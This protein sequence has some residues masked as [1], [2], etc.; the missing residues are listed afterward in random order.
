M[1]L[2]APLFGGAA[3]ADI[4]PIGHRGV[5]HEL[6]LDA[7]PAVVEGWQL[8]A[9]PWPGLSGV[10]PVELGVPF[11]FSSKYGTRLYAVARD[12]ALPQHFEA[13][14]AEGRP[15]ADF[16]VREV[17]SVSF[18]SLLGGVT[19]T[20]RVLDVS[21]SGIRLELIGEE[22]RDF[23]G[24]PLHVTRWLWWLAPVAVG[25]AG[26]ALHRRRRAQDA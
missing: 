21:A 19:T 22:R 12:E 24:A 23:T 26:I 17:G 6:V 9:A 13:A 11:R 15:S 16:G 14:W 7:P 3:G 10:T 1:L 5:A 8:V 18:A 2:A 20:L 4:L 25:L